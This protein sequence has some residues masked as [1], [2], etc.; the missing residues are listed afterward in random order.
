MKKIVLVM[1]VV[2]VNAQAGW[3][4]RDKKPVELP[5]VAGYL[6]EMEEVGGSWQE[7]VTRWKAG[8]R[9]TMVTATPIAMMQ[10]ASP[11]QRAR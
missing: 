9:T 11:M 4:S 1:L 5:P 7:C 2:V 6:V 10:T 3:F 8:P